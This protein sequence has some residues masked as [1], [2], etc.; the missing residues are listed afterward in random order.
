[1][2]SVILPLYNGEAFLKET[3]ESILNQTVK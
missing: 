3:I 2:I 1:M